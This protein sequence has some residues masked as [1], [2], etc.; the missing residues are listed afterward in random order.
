MSSLSEASVGAM[1]LIHMIPALSEEASGPSYSVSRLCQS[2]ASLD[3]QVSL[4]ALDWA[5]L[6]DPPAFLKTFALGVGPKRLGRS[7][8]MYRWLRDQCAAGH[9]DVVHNHG[10]WQMNA[11]YPAW[12]TRQTG[13]RLVY[14]PRGAF[15]AWAMKHGSSAKRVF[16]SLLQH[17]ALT[18]ADC[19][20]AT[21]EAELQ[22]IRRLGF[23]QPVAIIPNGIDLQQVPEAG[24]P[25][26]RTLLFLGRIYFFKWLDLLLP[27]WKSVQYRCAGWRRVIVGGDDFYHR[28]SAYFDNVKQ[29]ILAGG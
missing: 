26:E 20:H 8:A 18:Q 1:R 16:W 14:S 9:V 21:A 29:E 6:S 27:E 11:I 28:A 4:A 5:P 10:M 24:F 15:S 23:K 3:N 25:K 7:P 19:F 12:A 13:V 2:L 22:D 17:K